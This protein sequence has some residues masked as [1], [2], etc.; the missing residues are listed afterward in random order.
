MVR[1]QLCE[2]AVLGAPV[3]EV[4]VG[5]GS[6]FQCRRMLRSHFHEA[7]GA[8]IW[9]RTQEHCVQNGEYGGVRANPESH[10]DHHCRMQ[11]WLL[12]EH[13]HAET[14]IA[15]QSGRRENSTLAS[16]LLF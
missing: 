13:A 1:R 14:H 3:E 7:L 10:S 5:D 2:A 11:S 6:V 4:G 8:D 12:G 16:L 9:Q 15:S